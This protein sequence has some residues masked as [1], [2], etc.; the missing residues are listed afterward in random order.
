M[1]VLLCILFDRSGGATVGVAFPQHRI[2]GAAEDLAIAQ[3]DRFLRIV[4]RVLRVIGNG[5]ALCLQFLD[6]RL[7]LRYRGADVGQLD[8]VGLGFQAELAQF[9]EVVTDLLCCAQGFG[10]VR[11]NPPGKGNVPRLH[12]DS[13]RP[14]K[15]A[16]NRQQ[17]VGGQGRGFV[18]HR[19]V[20]CLR[21]H[22]LS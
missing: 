2:D 15:G 3:A 21:F 10:K 22:F 5:V 6:R 7:E 11:Q 19:V 1:R 17:G 13:R 8:D 4:L 20:D 12:G 16:D 9:S 14:G 18:D